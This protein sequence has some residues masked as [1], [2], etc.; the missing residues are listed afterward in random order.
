MPLLP[1]SVRSSLLRSVG[2]SFGLAV[3]GRAVAKGGRVFSRAP[4]QP[5]PQ[6]PHSLWAS[7]PQSSVVYICRA[8][9]HANMILNK[10][11]SAKGMA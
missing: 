5:R 2:C 1:P 10:N 7:A 8:S 11:S 6:Q 9:S 4:Q 3:H